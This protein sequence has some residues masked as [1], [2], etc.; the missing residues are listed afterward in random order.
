VYVGLDMPGMTPLLINLKGRRIV[1]VGGGKVGERKARFFRDASVTVISPEFTP[2]LEQMGAGGEVRLERRKVNRHML[3]GIFDNVFL[4][5]A[6]TSDSCLNEEI[7]EFCRE[8]GILANG[9]TGHTDVIVP[10][11]IERD[12]VLVAISTVGRSPA[13][14][15]YLRGKLEAALTSEDLAM[16]RLQDTLR[17][18][19]MSLVAGQPDRDRLLSLVLEDCRVRDALKRS[20]AE[21]LEIAMQVIVVH[22]ET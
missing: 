18:K 13:M 2:G 7:C 4:V 17:T 21:A 6:A 15:R 9:A 11:V 16:V 1:I 19:L 14:A 10:A 5:V 12:S 20:D 3:D 8:R 22:R